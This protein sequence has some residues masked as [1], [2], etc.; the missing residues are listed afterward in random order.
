MSIVICILRHIQLGDHK[1]E[2]EMVKACSTNRRC[3][4]VTKGKRPHGKTK[5]RWKDNVIEL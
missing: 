4:K 3:G 1:E 5:H 2:D